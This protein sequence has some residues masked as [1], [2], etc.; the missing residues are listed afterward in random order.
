MEKISGIYRIRNL[1]N[2][3][4]YIGQSSNIKRRWE[5]HKYKLNHQK[6]PNFHLQ[7]SW[8]KYEEKNFV[9]EIIEKM[10]N[11]I[12]ELLREREQYWCD[13]YDA[14]NP[15]KG[16][17]SRIIVESNLGLKSSEK[18]KKKLSEAKKGIKHHMYGKHHKENTKKKI[19]E[20]QIGSKNHNFG[21]KCL[22]NIKQNL[23][24]KFSGEGSSSAKLSWE[25]I[26]EIREKYKTGNYSYEKLGKFYN[27]TGSAIGRIINNKTWKIN[28]D[29][30][31]YFII[32]KKIQQ[33]NIKN[34]IKEK[35]H[36][37]GKVFDKEYREK[38]SKTRKERKI[39]IGENNPNSK[40]NWEKIREIRKKCL[41]FSSLKLAKEYGVGKATIL[42][43]INN[44]TW[45]I[46]ND[47]SNQENISINN[48]ENTSK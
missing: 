22:E 25:E 47:P 46:E 27:V 48:N 9:F 4:I 26:N 1:I 14:S 34:R 35:N 19:S 41:G 17:N 30:D 44:K 8:N 21:K 37:Y 36:N 20:S 43:I 7:S 6:H 45:K 42:R 15:S 12:K 29:L 39:G 2:N 40:L 23:S 38:I 31:L 13:F 3:K 24:N 28:E 11:S 33:D 32:I 5:D 10:K 18:T 16:Y